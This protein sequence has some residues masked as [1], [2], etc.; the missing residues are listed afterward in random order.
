MNARNITCNLQGQDSQQLYEQLAWR[1]QR[2]DQAESVNFEEWLDSPECHAWLEGEAEVQRY[3]LNGY[4]DFEAWD[5]FD[6]MDI[7]H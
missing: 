3:K 6:P 1:N 5:A 7:S 4:T 2:A